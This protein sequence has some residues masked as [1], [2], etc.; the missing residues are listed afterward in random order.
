MLIGGGGGGGNAIQDE[1]MYSGGGGGAGGLV[2]NYNSAGFDAGEKTVTIGAGGNGVY[3]RQ[4]QGNP[5]L[6]KLLMEM[7]QQ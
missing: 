3:Y 4:P 2:K 7:I 6:Y 1:S 5:S